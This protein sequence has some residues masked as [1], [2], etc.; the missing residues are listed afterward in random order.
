MI[1]LFKKI[2]MMQFLEQQPWFKSKRT[3]KTQTDN[4]RYLITEFGQLYLR[5]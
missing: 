1:Q 5:L 2:T 3:Q 4:T